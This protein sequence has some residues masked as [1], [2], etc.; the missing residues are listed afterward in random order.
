MASQTKTADSDDSNWLLPLGV[1]ALVLLAAKEYVKDDPTAEWVQ[2]FVALGFG[3]VMAWGWYL[4]EKGRPKHL[5]KLR[6]RL[7]LAFGL[8]GALGYCNFGNLHFGNY[9]HVWDTY[10]YYMGSKYFPEVKYDLLYDCTAIAD[11]EDGLRAQTEARVMTDLRTN[12]MH[13][14]S[15]VLANPDV[16]K[17]HFTPARWASYKHDVAF[18]RGRVNPTR[19]MEIHQDHGYNATPVWTLL[20]YALSNMAPASIGQ[21][22]ALLLLDPIF[23]ALMALMVWWAFGPRAFALGMIILG[24]NFPNRY[25]WTGGA[26]LRHDWVFYL[27]AVVCLLKKDR[28]WL[29]GLALA[30]ST[31]LRLFP[32]LLAVG[33]LLAGVEYLRVHRKLDPNFMKFVAGGALGCALLLPASFAAFGGVETWQKFAANTQKHASTP[34]TNHM[35]LRTVLSFRPSTIG[36]QMRDP[37]QID[38]WAKWKQMRLVK[39]NEAK[40]LFV[41]L[42]LACAGLI[43]LAIRNTG[44]DLWIAA[45]LG[46]GYIVAGAELTCYYYC[47]LITMAP[48]VT[49]RREVGIVFPVLAL[50]TLWVGGANVGWLDEQYAAMSVASM[51]ACIAIWFGFT[52]WG[53]TALLPPE[54]APVLFGESALAVANTPR[55]KKKRKKR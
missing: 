15:E 20:G 4:Y 44:T 41:L 32:G 25:Y 21:I 18:F 24:T 40:P 52:R 17:S 29:A 36:Q 30:Y 43:Y 16:C 27:V 9:I 48:L 28:P 33:P 13:Q 37:S 6:D 11:A 8:A 1:I 7:L 54:P 39:F 46:G 51:M 55:E 45:A 19:W 50:F 26:Y 53:T 42:L 22:T 12:V 10:H 38:A 3:G 2:A 35:G 31:L 14:A 34:L 5:H 49:L 23:L 47:F